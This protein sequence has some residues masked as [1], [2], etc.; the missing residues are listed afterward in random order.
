MKNLFNKVIKIW[1]LYLIIV[2]GLIFSFGFGV[3]VR[4]ELV[5]YV[6]VG[7]VSKAALFLLLRFLRV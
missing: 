2:L 3:L 5:G 6:K 1:V 4:Q 7:P